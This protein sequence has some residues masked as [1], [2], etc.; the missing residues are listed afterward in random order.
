M[1]R[2]NYNSPA[3]YSA[4]ILLFWGNVKPAWG[5]EKTTGNEKTKEPRLLLTA[6]VF[7]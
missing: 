1:A 4:N 7:E 2:A 3:R 6:F 5:N